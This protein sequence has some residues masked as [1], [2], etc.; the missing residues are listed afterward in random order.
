V[1]IVSA[2]IGAGHDA[3]G[4]ALAQAARRNW[5]GCEVRW[6]DIL[7]AMGPGIARL[8]R[9]FYTFQIQHVPWLYNMFFRAIWKHRWYLASTRHLLGI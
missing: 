9:G 4:R 8:A 2:A 6:L 1:P 7:D 5:P 3:T